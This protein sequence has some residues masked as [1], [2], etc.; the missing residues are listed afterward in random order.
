MGKG[1][2]GSLYVGASLLQCQRQVS[3]FLRQ[4]I[5]RNLVRLSGTRQQKFDGLVA[6]EF[7]H[8]E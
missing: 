4:L 8:L 7:L 5:C 1:A 6:L 2:A 3:Q